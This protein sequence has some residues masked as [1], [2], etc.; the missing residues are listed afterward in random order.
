MTLGCDILWKAVSR[1]RFSD[2]KFQFELPE[3]ALR[4][5]E[6]Y[7]PSMITNVVMDSNSALFNEFFPLF[8][9]SAL[10]LERD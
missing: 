1:S 5:L 6:G 3:H 10:P 7:V 4:I 8:P 9:A 2:L